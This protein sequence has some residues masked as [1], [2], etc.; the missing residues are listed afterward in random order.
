MRLRDDF[1]TPRAT[2]CSSLYCFLYASYTGTVS[3]CTFGPHAALAY[4]QTKSIILP[5]VRG[6]RGDEPDGGP[7]SDPLD[8]DTASYPRFDSLCGLRGFPSRTIHFWRK[9]FGCISETP[10]RVNLFTQFIYSFFKF[11]KNPKT[12]S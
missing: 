1:Q 10:V 4:L 9:S 11:W 12:G 3:E 2:N 6:G 5:P 8:S 7:P